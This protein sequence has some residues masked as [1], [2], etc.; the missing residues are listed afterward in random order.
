MNETNNRDLS[1]LNDDEVINA[2]NSDESEMDIQELFRKYLRNEESGGTDSDAGPSDASGE[3]VDVE[4]SEGDPSDSEGSAFSSGLLAKLK[5]MTEEDVSDAA[6]DV[7]EGS[8]E[9]EETADAVIETVEERTDAVEKAVDDLR[10]DIAIDAADDDE[11]E[12][13][14]AETKKPGGLFAR[15]K[16]LVSRHDDEDEEEEDAED[17]IA[18]SETDREEDLADAGDAPSAED[19]SEAV[20]DGAKAAAAA[21]VGGLFSRL[22]AWASDEQDDDEEIQVVDDDASEESEKT[23]EVNA[24]DSIP[25]ETAADTASPVADESAE[26]AET[27]AGE[28]PED[29]HQQVLP[30]FTEKTTSDEKFKYEE[31]YANEED[32]FVTDELPFNDVQQQAEETPAGETAAAEA[33]KASDVL[34]EAEKASEQEAPAETDGSLEEAPSEYLD[35][36]EFEEEELSDTDLNLMVVFGM[37][38]E[39]KKKVGAEHADKIRRDSSANA[40]RQQRESV[41][42]EFTDRSQISGIAKAYKS[43]YHVTFVKLIIAA[44][45]MLYLLFY[46]NISL[47]GIQFSGA[48]DPK[49]Y[50]VVY[51]MVG[52]QLGLLACVCAY[53]QILKG[54]R[55]IFTGRPSAESILAVAAVADVVYS[56]VLCAVAAPLKGNLH[57]YNATLA[58]CAVFVL[59]HDLLGIRREMVSFNVVSSK[60]PKYVINRIGAANAPDETSAFNSNS[61]VLKIEKTNFVDGFFS[62]VSTD[63]DK[64]N[65]TIGFISI[66]AVLVSVFL[67]V[68]AAFVE[69]KVAPVRVA[70]MTFS[71]VYPLSLLLVYSLPFY[72]ASRF[73]YDADTAIVGECSLEEY[74]DVSLVSVDESI[75]YPSYGVKVQNVKVFNNYRIDKVLYYA[76]S[77]FLKTGGPLGSVFESATNDIGY[78]EN[79]E[80]LRCEQGILSANVDGRKVT[81]GKARQLIDAGYPDVFPEEEEQDDP[82]I[83]VMYMFREDI[84]VAEMY[85]KYVMDSD[86]EFLLSDLASSGMCVCIRS[87]DPNIDEELLMKKV[88]LAQY[89][90]RVVKMSDVQAADTVK[91]RIDSGLVSRGTPKGLL[92]S[93]PYCDEVLHVRNLAEKLAWFFVLL[94]SVIMAAMVLTGNAGRLTSLFACLYQLLWMVPTLIMSGIFIKYKF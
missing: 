71:F 2:D 35:A 80:L 65:S 90:L 93:Q 60:N 88:D 37:D 43:T 87:F 25:A 61:D 44:A 28:V 62:R 49:V 34:P 24:V 68:I 56:I 54:F 86:F 89:P 31:A 79:V 84:L 51:I 78:S 67:A 36:D 9:A 4:E 6:A 19:T 27:A 63:D 3:I 33:E 14:A 66:V 46:E 47:L 72:R 42:F 11:T 94:S 52:L 58:M 82:E 57:L 64:K 70:G 39:L 1:N 48:F 92:Q 5:A 38:D 7:R 13:P 40:P 77:L 15:L 26:D 45:F 20:S 21:G 29:P 73:S 18:V 8:A 69:T 10:E 59:L 23:A 85:L 50:P 16:S 83:S 91:D 74:A 53:E 30:I 41:E 32:T 75:V 17:E 12:V 81:F 22:K 76:S 55:R